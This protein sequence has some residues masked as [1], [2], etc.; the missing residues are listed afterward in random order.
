MHHEYAVEPRVMGSNWDTFRYLIEKFGFDKGRLIA[1]FPRKGWFREVYA[2]ADGFSPTQKTRLEILLK[3]ARGTKV[4]RS[5]RPY[6]HNIEWFP[7]ALKEH[8]RLPFHAIIARENA[9]ANDVVLVAA[10][11][12]EEHP[13]ML[14]PN[15]SAIPRDA[16]SIATALSALLVYGARILVVD[17]FYNP[18]NQRYKDA[19]RA[20]LR[21]VR[22]QNAAT[23]CEI[24]Y[25]YHPDAP[26]PQ[27]IEREAEHIFPGVIPDGGTLKIFCWKERVGGADFHAR[28]L[29]TDKGGIGVDAGFSAEGGHQTTDMHRMDSSF[30]R[31]R[32]AIFDRAATV[33]ELVEPVLLI[34]AAGHV[35]HA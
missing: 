9:A 21:I 1:E 8:K 17:P 32:V 4:I 11:M 31:E 33:Y 5:G 7:N 18:F 23:V 19:L 16:T 27:D 35:T 30:C 34:T 28:Y 3:E 6:D 24:H 29:L 15:S 2:A 10:E 22:D 13:L 14:A 26:A 20:C 25:R 12:D